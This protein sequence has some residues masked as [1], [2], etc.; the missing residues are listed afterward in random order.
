MWRRAGES[1][2]VGDGI[3]IE[4]LEAKPH[5]VKLGIVA[6]AS[7]AI[8]RKEARIT[9]EENLAAALSAD[10]GMID[11]LLRRLPGGVPGV[12]RAVTSSKS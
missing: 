6:P 2:L 12:D 9:R 11:N 10:Q 5:R 4:V 7:V 1:F 3:E 8:V